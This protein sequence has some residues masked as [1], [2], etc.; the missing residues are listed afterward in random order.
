M[1]F[2]PLT[3]EANNNGSFP[4]LPG[5]KKC[6]PGHFPAP[7]STKLQ[8]EKIGIQIK[9]FNQPVQRCNHCLLSLRSN[10]VCARKAPALMLGLPGNIINPF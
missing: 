9:A 6:R 8:R 7:N 10:G 5:D 3:K 4:P 1:S 2:L